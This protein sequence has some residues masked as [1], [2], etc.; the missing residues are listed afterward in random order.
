MFRPGRSGSPYF[1]SNHCG[2]TK[3]ERIIKLLDYLGKRGSGTGS[4]TSVPNGP[5]LSHLSHL[6]STTKQLNR[7]QARWYLELSA[8]RFQNQHAS[9]KGNKADAFSRIAENQRQLGSIY[10]HRTAVYE[11]GNSDH[12]KSI[13]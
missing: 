11:V 7:R 8:Y 6:V 12:P 2:D 13:F 10:Q 4:G 5:S 3:K 1:G 9:G